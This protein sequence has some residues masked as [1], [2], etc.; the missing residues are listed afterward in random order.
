MCALAVLLAG[1]TER[2]AQHDPP[3]RSN[4]P[5]SSSSTKRPPMVSHADIE[6]ARS[7]AQPPPRVAPT[8]RVFEVNGTVRRIRDNTAIAARDTLT[9]LSWIETGPDGRVVFDFPQEGRVVVHPNSRFQIGDDRSMQLILASGA[10][11]GTLVPI[12]NA[13]RA[14]LRVATISSTTEITGSGHVL[15]VTSDD[16]LSST[17]TVLLGEISMHTGT[18]E[19]TGRPVSTR[20]HAGQTYRAGMAQP[21]ALT[22]GRTGRALGELGEAPEHSDVPSLL[23]ARGRSPRVCAPSPRVRTSSQELARHLDESLTAAERTLAEQRTLDMQHREVS[24]TNAMGAVGLMS[25]IA[26]KAQLVAR[27]R[28]HNLTLWESAQAFEGCSAEIWTA[29]FLPLKTRAQPVVGSE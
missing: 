4:T 22:E 25:A 18:R 16:G 3:R 23:R 2:N 27:N 19:A 29:T 20:V 9:A 13:P 21:P 15:V 10:A 24:R 6:A 8:A 1:C 17:T 7:M 26:L 11:E 14:P 12:G 28:T 5:A